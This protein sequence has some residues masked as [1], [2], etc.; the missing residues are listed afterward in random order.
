MEILSD[1]EI[2]AVAIGCAFHYGNLSVSDVKDHAKKLFF[3]LKDKDENSN[4]R[5]RFW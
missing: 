1:N 3:T 2:E 5:L 4:N